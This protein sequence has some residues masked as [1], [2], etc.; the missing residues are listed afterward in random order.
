MY[1][2][3]QVPK[4]VADAS[5]LEKLA[6]NSSRRKAVGV[7]EVEAAVAGQVVEV[8]KTDS[9]PYHSIIHVLD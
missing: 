2:S 6:S 7:E 9:K 3:V 8:K 4:T 5:R 1:D